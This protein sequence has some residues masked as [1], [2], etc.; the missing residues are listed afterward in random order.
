[1]RLHTVPV[2]VA[3]TALCCASMGAWATEFGTVVSSTPVFASVPV[4][5]QQCVD[6]PVAYRRPNSG[7]GALL[8]AIAGAAIGNSFGGGTGRA[9]ATG[10]GM[11]TG[12]AVGDQV[13]SNGSPPV[14]TTAQRCHNV[15][16]YEN[17][18]IGYDVVYDFQGV[19][20]SVRL[21]QDPGDRVALDVNVSPVEGQ[22][23]RRQAPSLPPP[24]YGPSP[25][26]V[27]EPAPPMV[28][29]P[30]TM[31]V[32]PLPYIVIG[33]AW[34]WQGGWHGHRHY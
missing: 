8:G 19:R 34:G 26:V 24:V 31:Y 15:T 32:Q 7:G 21:A 2:K 6:E 13:E 33:G 27:Y 11:V 22:T 3:V 1:M 16:R 14:S 20:R 28:Y 30:P 23:Q 17:R 12:A 9:V 18:A 25:A 29:A 10:I 4:A 5:Q